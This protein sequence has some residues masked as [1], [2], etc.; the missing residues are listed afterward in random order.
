M[1]NERRL[2]FEPLVRAIAIQYESFPTVRPARVEG[3]ACC[4]TPDQ[5]CALVALPREQLSAADLD[6]YARKAITTIGGASE[7]RYFWPRLAELAIAGE[8]TTDTEIVFGKPCYGRDQEWPSA[9]Q[10]ALLDLARALGRWLGAEQLDDHAVDTWICSIGLLVEGIADVRPFLAPL[11]D[12]TSAAESNL[13]AF[14]EWNRASVER[15][16]RLTNGFWESAPTSAAAVLDWYAAR[17]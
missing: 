6:V 15:K 5:L 10:D 16:K 8:L 9:E 14:V 3:C 12:F 13:Q 7:F 17:H 1:D 4:T 11:L 2:M